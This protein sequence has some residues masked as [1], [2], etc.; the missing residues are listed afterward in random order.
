MYGQAECTQFAQ[1][2]SLGTS[3]L[4]LLAASNIHCVLPGGTAFPA[5]GNGSTGWV[6]PSTLTVDGGIVS[7]LGLSAHSR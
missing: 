3:R 6:S 1:S 7:L 5:H 4:W 2:I